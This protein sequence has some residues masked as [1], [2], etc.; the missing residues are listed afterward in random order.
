[1]QLFTRRTQM[2]KIQ[3]ELAALNARSKLLTGK[4]AAAQSTLDSAF[5][6]RQK[7]L[8]TGDLDDTKA[9]MA[10]Q[11]KVDKSPRSPASTRRS[12][13]RPPSSPMPRPSWRQSTW[14]PTARPPV[15]PSRRKSLSSTSCS[16]RGWR[17]RAIWPLHWKQSTGALSPPKWLVSSETPQARSRTPPP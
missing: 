10:L 12:R 9:A 1:M 17:L 14:T 16:V 6:A 3:S 11:A 8:L 13:R 15:T 4:R 5:E 7:A 2:Q